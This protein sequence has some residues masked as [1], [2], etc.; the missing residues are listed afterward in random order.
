MMNRYYQ[1]EERKRIE[2]KRKVEFLTED[3]VQAFQGVLEVAKHLQASSDPE[4][5]SISVTRVKF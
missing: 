1:E 3:R 2:E 5:N 4:A